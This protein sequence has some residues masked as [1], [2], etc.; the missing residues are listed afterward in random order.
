[1]RVLQNHKPERWDDGNYLNV[2]YRTIPI[3]SIS[4]PDEY[5]N[6][7]CEFP[8]T[9]RTKVTGVNRVQNPYMYGRF[10]LRAEQLQVK[11]CNVFEA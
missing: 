1:P 5:N 6:V 8:A 2:R 10:V 7:L 9:L 3:T 11:G 4:H